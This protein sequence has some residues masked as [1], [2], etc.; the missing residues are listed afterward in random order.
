MVENKSAKAAKTLNKPD[1]LPKKFVK[2]LL[3]WNQ[4][5]NHRQMPWKGETDPYKIWLSEIILQQTRVEQGWQYYQQFVTTF[6][7]IM[8][9]AQ[10]PEQTVYKLWEGLGYYSR[11]RNLIATARYIADELDGIFPKTYEALV[12]LKGVGPYTAAAIASFAYHLPY[13]VVDGNVFRVLSRVFGIETP[14]DTTE[15]KKQFGALAQQLLPPKSAAA[16]N[17]AIMDFGATVC[18]PVPECTHCFFNKHCAAFLHNQ[19]QHLPV[20]S[21]Q[22]VVKERWFH[23]AV[24]RCGDQYA[25][26]QRTEKDIWPY[27]FEFVL[28]ETTGPQ[29]LEAVLAMLK[30]QYGL[31]KKE[32]IQVAPQPGLTQKLSHQTVHFSFIELSLH[33]PVAL[34]DFRC[35]DKS[36]LAGF[37]FPKTLQRYIQNAVLK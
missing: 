8:A 21:K 22:K 37:P 33:Q 14:I 25:I 29:P 1:I 35:V 7:T 3:Y 30:K 5:G 12:Q 18:K 32:Y 10:A 9:L 34:P 19:Q 11:C 36:Q 31:G 24:L 2:S 13:A 23:Y 20:R 6:P 16:Y 28:F 17:Q 15:G 4:T 27:L 26:H